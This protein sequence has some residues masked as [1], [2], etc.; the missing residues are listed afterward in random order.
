VPRIRELPAQLQARFFEAEKYAG[1]EATQMKKPRGVCYFASVPQYK[2]CSRVR[3][4]ENARH[5]LDW[6]FQALF[7]LLYQARIGQALFYFGKM[8]LTFVL[9]KVKSAGVTFPFSVRKITHISLI[10]IE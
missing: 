6:I 5:F 8:P 10:L 1:I 2:R 3:I 4:C 7:F 9:T